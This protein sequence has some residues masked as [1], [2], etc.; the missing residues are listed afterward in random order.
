M[1]SF[2]GGKRQRTDER[3]TSSPIP[4]PSDTDIVEPGSGA[5]VDSRQA[6]GADCEDGFALVSAANS[7]EPFPI[8]ELLERLLAKQDRIAADVAHLQSTIDSV[9]TTLRH[10]SAPQRTALQYQQ[11]Q[12]ERRPFSTAP[13]DTRQ[14]SPLHTW[15]GGHASSTVPPTLTNIVSL[16]DEPSSL[17]SSMPATQG[18]TLGPPTSPSATSAA[19]SASPRAQGLQYGTASNVRDD[20]AANDPESNYNIGGGDSRLVSHPHYANELYQPRSRN[21]ATNVYSTPPPPSTAARTAR[22]GGLVP[23]VR[24][25]PSLLIQGQSRGQQQQQQHSTSASSSSAPTQ[26]FSSV[27]TAHPSL[28]QQQQQ[29]R[30]SGL[31]LAPTPYQQQTNQQYAAHHAAS[32]SPRVHPHHPHH[33]SQHAEHPMSLPPIRTSSSAAHPYAGHPRSSISQRTSAAS[34]SPYSS[35]TSLAS[36]MFAGATHAAP[37]PLHSHNQSPLPSISGLTRTLPSTAGGAAARTPTPNVG[38]SPTG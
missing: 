29:Q 18:A 22:A 13:L 33:P 2:D 14:R 9:L 35:T 28:Q 21:P 23:S 3:H 31:S 15:T 19:A 11:Q 17:L 12:P 38:S 20:I 10:Q 27:R 16:R 5:V 36:A 6:I 26:Q 25:P 24:S 7:V 30:L 8:H 1:S 4:A 32:S 37:K 34:A